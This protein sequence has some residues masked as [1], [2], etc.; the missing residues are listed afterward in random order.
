MIIPIIVL[1]IVFILIA[2]RDIGKFKLQIWQVM[3]GGAVLVLLTGQITP[4]DAFHA[5][6][7]DVIFFLFGMFIVGQAT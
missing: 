6:D 4:I 5:I 2:A 7:F 3:L 1:G